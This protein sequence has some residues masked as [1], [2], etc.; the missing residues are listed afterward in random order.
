MSEKL[1]QA[2]INFDNEERCVRVVSECERVIK[3]NSY[4]SHK[5]EL[6]TLTEAPFD[7]S[8][9]H[10]SISLSSFSNMRDGSRTAEQSWTQT[11]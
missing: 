7:H 11:K 6:F 9:V 2:I 10:T 3:V 4:D 1:S 5:C 8:G